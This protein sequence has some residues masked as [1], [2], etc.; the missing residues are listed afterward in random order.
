MTE[1]PILICGGH[2]VDPAQGEPSHLRLIAAREV[3]YET[4]DAETVFRLLAAVRSRQT[5][6]G[7]EAVDL[8]REGR[9]QD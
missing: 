7:W 5:A 8:A 3:A 4:T 1:R 9:T 2:L 6:A